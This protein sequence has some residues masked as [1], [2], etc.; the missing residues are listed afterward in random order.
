M[1]RGCQARAPGTIY[2][3]PTKPEVDGA[4]SASMCACKTLV[5]VYSRRLEV[6]MK[7]VTIFL[8]LAFA[9]AAFAQESSSPE[10]AQ[11]PVPVPE[12]PFR[13]V[14]DFLKLPPDLY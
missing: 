3:A 2:R 8:F 4:G 11:E 13:S 7:R 10:R 14:A 5:G 6:T 12:I 9:G 1:A